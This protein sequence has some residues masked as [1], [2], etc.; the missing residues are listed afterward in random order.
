MATGA[1]HGIE[2]EWF[3]ECYTIQLIFYIDN[4]VPGTWLSSS[5]CRPRY[6]I[7]L[8]TKSVYRNN[9][10]AWSVIYNTT[11]HISYSCLPLLNAYRQ[12]SLL[13]LLEV[14][15]LCRRCRQ[16]L[17]L[18]LASTLMLCMLLLFL[19]YLHSNSNSKL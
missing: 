17:F 18:C 6:N 1:V 10:S 19:Y 15:K 5:P 16:W 12:S 2:F 8:T 14:L 13:R 4:A 7:I 9:G 11:I 3:C